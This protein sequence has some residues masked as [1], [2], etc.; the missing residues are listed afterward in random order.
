MIF[1]CNELPKDVEHSEAYFR[2][3]LIIPFNITIPENEQDKQL[4]QKIIDT[5]LSGV[6]NWVLEGLSRLLKQKKFTAS[7]TV[8]QE[9]IQYEKESDSVRLFLDEMNYA[10]SHAH[11]I[12]LKNLYAEYRDFCIESGY[13]PVN[14]LNFRKRLK[15]ANIVT[16][17]KNLGNVAFLGKGTPSQQ[18]NTA[19]Q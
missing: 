4:A 8:C 1:N 3:L 17:R 10:P 9:R 11:W 13:K 16:E 7:E 14:S 6:F 12:Q 5:E 18:I 15:N 2:R 19:I